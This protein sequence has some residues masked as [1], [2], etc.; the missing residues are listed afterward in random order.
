MRAHDR[1]VSASLA[2]TPPAASGR[3]P[4]VVLVEDDDGLRAALVRVLGAWRFEARAYA[5]A[6]AALADP[7][8]EAP[9]CLVV[10]LNLPAMSGLDLV[11]RLRQRG[12]TAPAVAITAQDEA[13]VRAEV[14]RRGVEHV[15]VKPFLGSAL[16]ALIHAVVGAPPLRGRRDA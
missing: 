2:D 4:R 13:R 10:D 15:L 12:V 9:D 14:K 11:D 6:E 3:R 16:A 8:L 1:Q 7:R 5:S